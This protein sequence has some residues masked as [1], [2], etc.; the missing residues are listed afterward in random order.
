MESITDREYIKK[1]LIKNCG[2]EENRE[3]EEK[4]QLDGETEICLDIPSAEE[5]VIFAIYTS[6]ITSFLLNKDYSLTLYPLEQLEVRDFA[7]AKVVPTFS[8]HSIPISKSRFPFKT[9]FRKIKAEYPGI[10]SGDVK[11][12]LIVERPD[13]VIS[14]TAY[15]RRI[16]RLKNLIENIGRLGKYT[17]FLITKLGGITTSNN[18]KEFYI[19]EEFLEYVSGVIFRKKGYLVGKPILPSSDDIGAYLYPSLISL[20]KEKGIIEG[21]GAFFAEILLSEDEVNPKEIDKI[22]IDENVEFIYIEA[23]SKPYTARSIG[24]REAELKRGYHHK[25]FVVGP[26]IDVKREEA[27]TISFA[28]DGTLFFHDT[29]KHSLGEDEEIAKK[30]VKDFVKQL[31]F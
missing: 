11:H 25:S 13:T 19:A 26:L 4:L 31:L 9:T 20:L 18:P 16:E 1:V 7:P 3:L 12:L 15:K 28:P 6:Y 27:G 8:S 29:K 22:P 21:R 30:T 2:F 17:D 5:A 23:E 14:K 24:F 10:F